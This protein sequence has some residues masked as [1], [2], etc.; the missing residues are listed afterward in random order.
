MGTLTPQ[1]F[2]QRDAQVVE[3]YLAKRRSSPEAVGRLRLSWS[4]WGFGTESLA[5]SADRLAR[6]GLRFIE[7]HGNRYGPD[8]GYRTGD[9]RAILDAT[10]MAVS[11]ICGM[12][13]ADNEFASNRQHVRQ[14]AID[15]FRRQADFC[16]E[17]GGSYVLVLP[18][19]VGRPKRYDGSEFDRAVEG[20]RIVAEHFASV[21]V[22]GA[23]EPIRPDEVSLLHTFDDARRLIAAID[24]PGIAHI[25][26]DLYHMLAGEEHIGLAILEAG[27]LLVNL[28]MADT[29]RRALGGGL[30]DLDIVLMALY[31]IGY[32]ER[33]GY[34]TPEPLGAGSDPYSAMYEAPDAS[35][36]D[37]LVGQTALTFF[38]RE[39]AL[40]AASDDQVRAAYGLN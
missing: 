28:H 20:M 2:R 9:V 12:A 37:A 16:A 7:L 4:N 35:R 10:G 5:V 18:G 33:G 26:G 21:G 3:A 39:A 8:L 19:A 6:S 29:N 17:I 31:A 40:R 36:L 11:G 13:S 24:H 34:C 1:A 22:R 30:L 32:A 38:E 25:N 15:Y 23:V 14:R 27:D